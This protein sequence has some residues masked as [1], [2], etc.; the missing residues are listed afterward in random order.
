MKKSERDERNERTT[1]LG[2]ELDRLT[3]PVVMEDAC[4]GSPSWGQYNYLSSGTNFEHRGDSAA[5]AASGVWPGEDGGSS[6]AMTDL[7]AAGP[8]DQQQ[9]QQQ[10]QQQQAAAGASGGSASTGGGSSNSG[11]G[12]EQ[13]LSNGH[14]PY[15]D[16][17]PVDLSS[18]RPHD[19]LDNGSPYHRDR[20]NPGA[21]MIP[22]SLTPPDKM[23]G[24]HPHHG[25][26]GVAA[27]A[28]AAM[29]HHFSLGAASMAGHALQTPPSPIPTP[30]PPV[31]I[32]RFR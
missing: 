20:R 17:H 18:P 3:M 27:A 13:H 7:S 32:E 5:A 16:N 11:G 30:S 23:N 6:Q 9:Q 8:G 4:R 10:H 1:Q 15:P 22:G 14:A 12:L 25:T 19:T 2:R 26:S 24:E 31:P 29:S 28:A 21:P